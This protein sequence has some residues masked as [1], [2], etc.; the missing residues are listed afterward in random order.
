MAIF[1]MSK[2][3]EQRICLKCCIS[4]KISCAEAL[5]NGRICGKTIYGFCTTI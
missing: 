1:I 2:N 4:N 3:Q 5:K